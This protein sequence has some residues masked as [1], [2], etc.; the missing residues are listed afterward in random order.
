LKFINL[1]KKSKPL[2]GLFRATQRQ[3]LPRLRK[4]AIYAGENPLQM[5]SENADFRKCGYQKMRILS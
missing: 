2:I 4:S 1:S 3:A 5:I